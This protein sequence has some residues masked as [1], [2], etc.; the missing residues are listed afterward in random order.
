MGAALVVVGV[1]FVV[2]LVV[3][4][5]VVIAL[6]VLR[7]RRPRRDKQREPGDT[8]IEPEYDHAHPD[9]GRLTDGPGGLN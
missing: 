3:G 6:P 8:T 1:F 2:G 4:G 7:A 9:D 5:I